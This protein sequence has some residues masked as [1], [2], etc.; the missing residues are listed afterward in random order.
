MIP[1]EVSAEVRRSITALRT[2]PIEGRLLLDAVQELANGTRAEGITTHVQ[3]IGQECTLLPQTKYA[4]YRMVQEALTNVRRH[5][6]ANQVIVTL[7]HSKD[8][9]MQLIVQDDGVGA[10]KV[11]NTSSD[12][13]ADTLAYSPSNGGQI[14]PVGTSGFGLIGVC[15]RAIA[16]GGKARIETAPGQGFTLTV[17]FPI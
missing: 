6:H 2:S 12:Y 3:V 10:T 17:E 1:K 11:N 16:L 4:V 14:N 13:C 15:E 8:T 5:A 9:W 7:D